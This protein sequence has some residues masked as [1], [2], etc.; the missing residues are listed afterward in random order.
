MARP[1]QVSDDEILETA[2]SVFLQ[3]GAKVSTSVIAEALGVSAAA[4]FKRFGNKKNLLFEALGPGRSIEWIEHVRRGPDQRPLAVQLHDI[5]T[6][7]VRFFRRMMPAMMVVKSA[8]FS[9]ED[10]FALHASPP[11]VQAIDALHAWFDDAADRG[12]VRP[13]DSR[14]RAMAFLGMFTQRIFLNHVLG[15]RLDVGDDEAFLQAAVE[16]LCDGLAPAST[17]TPI[18]ASAKESP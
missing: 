9:P 13:G 3:R 11:P 7:A 8:G 16:L 15:G 14:A 6:R 1:R 5:A 17:S 4:L 12:L 18:A 2:R 10:F